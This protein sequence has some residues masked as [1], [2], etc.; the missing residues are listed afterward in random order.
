MSP[1]IFITLKS[2]S[3]NILSLSYHSERTILFSSAIRRMLSMA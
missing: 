2:K 3:V 1:V